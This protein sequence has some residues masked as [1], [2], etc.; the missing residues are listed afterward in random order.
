[1]ETDAQPQHAVAAAENGNGAHHDDG[2]GGD[3]AEPVLGF[4]S[5]QEEPAAATPDEQEGI[6]NVNENEI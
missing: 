2:G 1:M 4:K 3:A 6:T 5:I